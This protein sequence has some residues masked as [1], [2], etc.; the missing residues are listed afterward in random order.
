MAGRAGGGT[1]RQWSSTKRIRSEFLDAARE[2][3]TRRGFADASVSEVVERAGSSVGSL[4]HHFGGKSEL[5]SAL[6]VRY[7]D[8]QHSVVA[9][10]VVDAR[11]AGEDDPF[12][13]FEV[14]ARAYLT[15]TWPNRDMVK[16]MY[17]G[18]TP[19][20][21]Q[22]L[23]RQSG[24]EWVRSNLRLLGADSVP[25]NRVLVALLTSFIGDARREIAAAR[26]AREARQMIESMMVILTQLRPVVETELVSELPD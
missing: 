13:L 12:A 21:F 26:S 22:K 11:T 15:A 24:Q 8:E 5:F 2:V 20:G 10:A 9:Q 18:D 7:R 4:Y 6:W 25:V 19:P 23:I 1:T 14:G 3:F 17:D 16:L